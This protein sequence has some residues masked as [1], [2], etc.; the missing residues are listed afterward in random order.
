MQV[1]GRSFSY[2]D[3]EGMRHARQARLRVGVQH[4]FGAHTVVEAGY[5]HARSGN[6]YLSQNLNPL[7]ANYWATGT[8][9]NNDIATELNRNVTNPFSLGNFSALQSSNPLVYQDMSTNSFYTSRTIRKNQLLRPN[10]QMTGLTSSDA[11]RGSVRADSIEVS[12]QRRF[13]KGFNLN[14]YYT[15]MRQ[16]DRDI[17][18]NEFDAEPSWRLSNSSRPH[19]V[20]ATSIYEMPFGKGRR[21]A[22]QSRVANLL[23]G[24]WQI[25]V[26]YE[27]QPGAL[28]GWGNVFYYGDPDSIGGGGGAQTLDQWFN[29]AGVGCSA[30]PGT[31][32]P[33]FERCSTR[34]PAAYH[35]R[36][37]PTRIDGLR[38]GSTN[39][40]NG[41]VIR[42]IGSREKVSFQLRL[43]VINVF[44]RSEW[45]AP[46]LDPF[47]TN[48][49]R[50]T[51]VTS[52]QKRFLQIQGRIRF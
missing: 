31:A 20:S 7:P 14:A 15:G 19:R 21:F 41:N 51:A 9:R 46:S 5:I 52:A 18:L 32:T 42:E 13:S 10:P 36:V 1:A 29:T 40:W 38:Q 39:T 24:G 49:G 45:D 25:G 2:R 27:Y 4:Q 35:Q 23:A 30:T 47:S 28:L 34:G 17:F 8:V 12:I 22:N 43:D 26:T 3:P 33:G 37:F 11:P 48:F 6:V 44:N 50:V 16:L